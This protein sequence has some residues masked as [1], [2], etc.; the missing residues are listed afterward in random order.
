MHRSGKWRSR[1]KSQHPNGEG[2]IQFMKQRSDSEVQLD[3]SCR[4]GSS[5]E[6]NSFTPEFRRQTTRK[7]KEMPMKTPGDEPASKEAEITP[8]PPSL[9]ARLMGLDSLPPTRKVRNQQSNTGNYSQSVTP[10]GFEKKNVFYEDHSHQRSS[11]EHTEFK[12]VF[13]VNE[14]P[15]FKKHKNH[16]VKKVALSSEKANKVDINFVK[17]KFLD[18]KRLSTDEVLQNSKEFNDALEILETNKDLFL[19]FLQEPNSLFSKGL[20]DLNYSPHS[21]ASHITILKPSKGRNAEMSSI[22]RRDYERCAHMSREV[23]NPSRKHTNIP[24]SHSLKEHSGYLREGKAESCINPT[25]IVV[26]KPSIEKAKNVGDVSSGH[27]GFPFGY[28]RP[29]EFSVSQNER[30]SAEENTR[31][32]LS[33]TMDVWGPETKASRKT[34]KEITAQMQETVTVRTRR[35]IES[36][37]NSYV[38]SER[39]RSSS[40]HDD[41]N[42]RFS[43]SSTHSTESSVSREARKRLS[44]RWKITNRFHKGGSLPSGSSTLG[45]ILALSDGEAQ[46]PAL[47]QMVNQNISDDKLLRDEVPGTLDYPL[48]ISS[49][50]GWKVGRSGIA[51][52]KS[53]PASSTLHESSKPR[54]RK[55]AGQNGDFYILKDVLNMGADDSAVG[56]TSRRGRSRTSIGKYNGDKIPS[57]CSG[58]EESMLPEREIH[59]NSEELRKS[60]PA[61]NLAE[62]IPLNPALS[63]DATN[64]GNDLIDSCIATDSQDVRHACPTQEENIQ[65]QSTSAVLMKDENILMLNQDDMVIQAAQIGHPQVDVISSPCHIVESA[66]LLSSKE[67]EQPSPISVLEPPLEEETSCS[68]CFDKISADLKELRMQLQLLKMESENSDAEESE[69]LTVN[70]EDNIGDIH[71]SPSTGELPE[72][73]DDQER[74]FSYLVDMLVDFNIHHANRDELLGSCFSSDSPLSLDVFEKLEKKYNKMIQWARSER[75]LLFDL[76]N[77]ILADVISSSRCRPKRDRGHFVEEVWQMV[78]RQRRQP[79]CTQEIDLETKWLGL[80]G[81]VDTVGEEI[82]KIIFDHLMKELVVEFIKVD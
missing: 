3:S 51:R 5:M 82:E 23:S 42:K 6:G 45:E 58:G 75:K 2:F 18:A 41:R 70:D 64:V 26:L 66:S 61:I 9:I 67:G 35:I 81:S 62:E 47:R 11:D 38:G 25:R 65:Q 8:P 78:V 50:D 74:D 44:E 39:S 80:G 37:C 29:M 46:N 60:I 4:S 76:A 56:Q 79:H 32:K 31:S 12:D 63:D 16:K 55:R 30:L 7:D 27:E 71:T 53:L 72:A 24:I 77:S 21:D 34:A 52:S 48:G 28:K 10:V 20:Q 17:Q 1:E 54:N 49:K 69:L 22:L 68:S 73:L 57:I 59:V 19:E 14:T 40:L 33:G 15:K 36:E 13:E 43:S